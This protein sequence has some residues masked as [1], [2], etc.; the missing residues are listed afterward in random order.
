MK[1]ELDIAGERS[2]ILAGYQTSD[3]FWQEL[4]KIL[5][6]Q[7]YS[8]DP[9]HY[10][11]VIGILLNIA[12]LRYE[13]KQKTDEMQQSIAAVVQKMDQLAQEN[14]SLRQQLDAL[15]KVDK[16]RGRKI[17]S[18]SEREKKAYFMMRD[19]VKNKLIAK[20]LGA[21]E[22]TISMMKKRFEEGGLM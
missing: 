1:K 21:S 22:A 12:C 13:Q 7:S 18:L 16:E 8:L 15:G 3:I 10:E 20:D 19:G 6:K 4:E 11:F 5:G 17:M 9:A 14:V 2:Q